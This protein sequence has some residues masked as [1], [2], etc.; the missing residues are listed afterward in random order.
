MAPIVQTLNKCMGD[1]NLVV[2]LHT[3]YTTM[4]CEGNFYVSYTNSF[5]MVCLRLSGVEGLGKI[6]KLTLFSFIFL[7][8]DFTFL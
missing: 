6:L 1:Y 3:V 2:E 7:R 8:S 4:H 5:D